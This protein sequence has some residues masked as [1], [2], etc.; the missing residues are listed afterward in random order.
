[1]NYRLIGHIR[2]FNQD[3]LENEPDYLDDDND[4]EEDEIPNRAH[5]EEDEE[6]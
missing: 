3:C 4:E 5:D 1:M 2:K 6:E